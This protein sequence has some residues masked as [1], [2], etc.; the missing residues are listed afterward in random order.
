MSGTRQGVLLSM[1]MSLDGFRVREHFV[2]Y[3]YGFSVALQ[4][5]TAV[6][7]CPAFP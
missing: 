7:K 5:G 3:G 1:I 4:V 6:I 2:S